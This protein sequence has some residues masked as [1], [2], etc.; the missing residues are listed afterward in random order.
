[1]SQNNLPFS[2]GLHR[3]VAA[4]SGPPLQTGDHNLHFRYQSS[5]RNLHPVVVHGR[6]LRQDGRH[7]RRAGVGAFIKRCFFVADEESVQ[8]RGFFPGKPFQL[9]LIFLFR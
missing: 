2:A 1:M 5:G 3:H 4:R 7:R 6:H 9:G 8:A